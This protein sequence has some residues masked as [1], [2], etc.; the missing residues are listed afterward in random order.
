MMADAVR[1]ILAQRLAVQVFAVSID[2]LAGDL[3]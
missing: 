3:A 2:V 1:E